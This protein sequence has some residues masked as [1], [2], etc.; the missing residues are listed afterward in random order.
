MDQLLSFHLTVTCFLHKVASPW[1]TL[2][3]DATCH[4]RFSPEPHCWVWRP[5]LDK[6]IDPGWWVV[7]RLTT[8]TSMSS[9]L[10]TRP[11]RPRHVS[12][13]SLTVLVTWSVVTCPRSS[14][15]PNCQPSWLVTPTSLVP[16]S[17]SNTRLLPLSAPRH[18]PRDLHLHRWLSSLYCTPQVERHGCTYTNSH[19]GKSKSHTKALPMLT[20]THHQPGQQGKSQPFV[21]S[22]DAWWPWQPSELTSLPSV[23]SQVHKI[24]SCVP[25]LEN[26]SNPAIKG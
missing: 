1:H 17:R 4:L 15:C 12:H 22:F 19:S 2:H 25:K 21:Y 13:Q 8:E 18:D 6:I 10:H 20:I 9:I 5:K 16:R 14:V 24:D 23:C 3:D 7:L 26:N 11:P